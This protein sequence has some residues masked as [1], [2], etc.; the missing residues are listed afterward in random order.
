MLRILVS[1]CIIFWCVACNS[2]DNVNNAIDRL[3]QK[4]NSNGD[5]Q[6]Q[7]N[8]DLDRRLDN[9]ETITAGLS[10]DVK[11]LRTDTDKN[12][13]DVV[14]VRN[15]GSRGV[16]INKKITKKKSSRIVG[17]RRD[18]IAPLITKSKSETVSQPI[19]DV[20]DLNIQ[21]S[22]LMPSKSVNTAHTQEVVLP[23]KVKQKQECPIIAIQADISNIKIEI[24]S[25]K[26]KDIDLQNQIHII[27]ATITEPT[28]TEI[29]PPIIEQGRDREH[30]IIDGTETEIEFIEPMDYEGGELEDETELD[31]DD[32]I[33]DE[34]NTEEEEISD[35]DNGFT[36][37]W[38]EG[39]TYGWT[40]GTMN[41]DPTLCPP[42]GD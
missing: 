23:Y 1:L 30:V 38:N 27:N 41:L 8:A 2:D 25:L 26:A 18:T 33:M 20:Q 11:G 34:E 12:T 37:G 19:A 22:Y 6:D 36:E 31:I 39:W 9:Q 40:H 5:L 14:K 35:Y 16:S 4:I 7:Y 28:I 21:P 32:V 17:T 24:E 10:S 42:E 15:N 29:E 13:A 3:I